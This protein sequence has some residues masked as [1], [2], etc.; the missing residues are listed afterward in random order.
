M[1]HSVEWQN[2]PSQEIN[3][4]DWLLVKSETNQFNEQL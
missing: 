2:F 1:A 4:S 3:G